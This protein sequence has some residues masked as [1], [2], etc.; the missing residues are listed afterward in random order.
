[1]Q[2]RFLWGVVSVVLGT[3]LGTTPLAA[4]R[5]FSDVEIRTI[6]LRGGV[7]MLMGSGGNIG[8]SVGEDGPFVVDDQYAGLSEKILAAIASIS[9][10]SVRFVLN[11]HWHGDHVGGNE[12]FG[13]AGAMIVAHENVRKRLNPEEFRE[14]MGNTQQAPPDALP[15]VTFTAGVTFY[16]NGEKIRAFHVPHAHTDGDAII[17]YGDANVIHMGD[18]FFNGSYPFIDVDSG[19]DIDGMIRAAEAGLAIANSQTQII[20]GHGELATP[21]DLREYRAM[22]IT[23]RDRIQTMVNDGMSVEEIVAARP[24]R[25]LDAEWGPEGWFVR[26]DRMAELTARSLI[27]R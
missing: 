23:V 14:V 19:G 9:D 26:G 4:Q 27:E 21:A 10:G 1:M 2:R 6:P 8:V 16:W 25:D 11:T 15:V 7:Y 17:H 5:D 18:T 12:N 22:L 24:T 3:G 13:K 20:P